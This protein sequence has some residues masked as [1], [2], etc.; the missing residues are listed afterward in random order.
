MEKAV[1]TVPKN[2]DGVDRAR[3]EAAVQK[4]RHR[5]ERAERCLARDEI[6]L[7]PEKLVIGSGTGKPVCYMEI[8]MNE[9]CL[10][11]GGIEFV[12]RARDETCLHEKAC[13]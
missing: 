6:F 12:S 4:R 3:S 7:Q 10:S 5:V 1:G 9:F 8:S 2:R 11:Y 13:I